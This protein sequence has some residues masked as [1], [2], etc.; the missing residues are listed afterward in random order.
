MGPYKTGVGP[1]AETVAPKTC[2]YNGAKL[3]PKVD[4]MRALK[5]FALP[6]L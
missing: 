2:L 4:M 6:R 3:L 1:R 5:L